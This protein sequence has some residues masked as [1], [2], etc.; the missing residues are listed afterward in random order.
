M[1][2]ADYLLAHAAPEK[3][4][5]ITEQETYTYADVIA[6]ADGMAR[7]LRDLGVQKGD[8][9]GIFADN[10]L[11]W[12]ASYIGVLKA[13]AVALPFYPTLEPEQFAALIA[14]TEP[15]AFCVTERYLRKY[16]GQYPEGVALIVESDDV[17]ARHGGRFRVAVHRPGGPVES[18]PVDD[19]ADLAALM[20]TSGSTGTPRAVMVSHRNIIANTDSIIAYLELDADERIMDV[21]PFYYCFGTSLLH[22]HFRVGGSV[23]VNNRFAFPKL[24]L[25]QMEETGCTG[26]AGVPSTYQILLRNSNFPERTF[27]KLRK[28][29]QAGGKLPNVFIEELRRAHPYADYYLMYGQTEATARLSYLPPQLLDTKLG[30]IG[31]GM[32]GVDLQVLDQEGNPVPPGVTGEIVARGD[33]ITLGYWRDL[34]ATAQSF[35]DGAL[36]TG[37]LAQVD[38][39]GFIFVVDRAKDFIKPSGHRVGSKQIENHLV[40][41]PE[42][43]EAAVIGVPDDVMGEAVMAFIVLRRGADIDVE[44]VMAHC[45][46]VM[47]PY[48]VPREIVVLN[49]LPKNASGKVD[50]TALKDPEFA[51]RLKPV[52][53]RT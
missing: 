39:D 7:T 46:R 29:Q 1:N 19:R 51:T 40:E 36:W 37:D 21:L 8:R 42:V 4:A 30:S 33:N 35:R 28:I 6:A 31:R 14:L 44:D 12:V 50:K 45:K 22:T 32:P 26:I 23:V 34:K 47:A 9:V 41:L 10:S 17:A 24:V 15:V 20:F 2:V 16:A 18:K 25:D 27:P 3:I 13:G 53:A 38:G 11:F 49:A 5:L 48:M 43:V 52:A